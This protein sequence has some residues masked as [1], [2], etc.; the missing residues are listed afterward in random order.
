MRNA[1]TFQFPKYTRSVASDLDLESTE[2]R[3]LSKYSFSQF[4]VYL[5]RKSRLRSEFELRGEPDNLGES[6]SG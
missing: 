5:V 3:D 1:I 2:Q 6:E 4:S